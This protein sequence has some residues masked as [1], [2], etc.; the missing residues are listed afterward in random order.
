MNVSYQNNAG[1]T[2]RLKISEDGDWITLIVVE[3][4]PNMQILS[5]ALCAGRRSMV[6][7]CSMKLPKLEK[8]RK[9]QWIKNG[10][11]TGHRADAQAKQVIGLRA[12][13]DELQRR[14]NAARE[15]EPK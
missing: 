9:R 10:D 4:S 5:Y 1:H 8:C 7:V 15:K 11:G 6:S 13:R 14:V 3:K 12:E 2:R